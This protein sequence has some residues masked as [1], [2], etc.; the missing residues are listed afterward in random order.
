MTITATHTVND[1][2][3]DMLVILGQFETFVP[4]PYYDDAKQNS[5]GQYQ[6]VTIGDGTTGDGAPLILSGR[7]TGDG[8]QLI[9]SCVN[10]PNGAEP[11]HAVQG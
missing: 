6:N 5:A 1:Y 8:A 10:N 7:T 9:L 4:T 2:I 11:C 3:A